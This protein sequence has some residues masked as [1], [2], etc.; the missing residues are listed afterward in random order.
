MKNKTMW[1][2]WANLNGP[3]FKTPKKAIFDDD[4]CLQNWWTEDDQ[5]S[6]N[7]T[8]L[9]KSHGHL[10]FA[11]P[12]KKEVQKFID[13]FMACRELAGGFFK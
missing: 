7:K 8:G 4:S 3:Q 6:V 9:E 10:I 13:G 11:D 5:L 12:D 2:F 1:A